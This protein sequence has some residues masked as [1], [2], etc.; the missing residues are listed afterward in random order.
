MFMRSRAIS[1]YVTIVCLLAAGSLTLLDWRGFFA[2]EPSTLIGF[3]ALLVLGLVSEGL[4]L[5]Y[6]VGK[7]AGNHSVTWIPALA[8]VLLFGPTATVVFLAVVNGVGEFLIRSKPRLKATFNIAQYVFSSTIAGLTFSALGGRA[9]AH[10]PG[11]NLGG[12]FSPQLGPFIAF[13]LVLYA[14]N[15]VLVTLAIAISQQLPFRNVWRALVGSSGTNVIYDLLVSPIAIVAAFLYFELDIMGLVLLLLPLFF[16]RESYLKNLQWQEANRDLLKVLVKAIETRDPYTSGHSLRV[17]GLAREL[18]IE[19]GL[20]S[21]KVDA[22]ETAA[23][24]HDIGKIEAVF[25]DILRKPGSLTREERTIIESHVTKGEELLKSLA[26][27]GSEVTGAVRHHHERVDGNGYPDGLIGEEIPVSARIIKV[28][29][30]VDAMLSDRPYREALEVSEV[31]NQLRL[32]SG[33][34]FD[35]QVA[36]VLLEGQILEEF[37]RDLQGSV[38]SSYPE[39]STQN[40]LQLSTG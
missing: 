29:D 12:E 25:S 39:F 3:V 40:L 33:L 23:L 27:F 34:Q 13:G 6:T 28:C 7:S 11:P 21:K 26:S 17:S 10:L 8:C 30:A 37:A 2:L 20:P 18:A 24:L 35:S 1:I 16:I 32:Y 15:H 4:S 19:L 36:S 22:V 9:L 5:S 31:K 38:Q 14:S